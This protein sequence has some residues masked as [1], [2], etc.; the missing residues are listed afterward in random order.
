MT[1]LDHS[2]ESQILVQGIQS[3]YD[4]LVDMTD[5]YISDGF[6]VD[7]NKKKYVDNVRIILVDIKNKSLSDFIKNAMNKLYINLKLLS[8]RKIRHIQQIY[9]LFLLINLYN[10]YS[11][12]FQLNNKLKKNNFQIKIKKMKYSSVSKFDEIFYNDKTVYVKYLKDE[13]INMRFDDFGLSKILNMVY[14]NY[15]VFDFN[16]KYDNDVILN[17]CDK[18][19][20]NSFIECSDNGNFFIQGVDSKNFIN[21]KN[22][23]IFVKK[24]DDRSRQNYDYKS[25][26]I[27]NHLTFDTNVM[28]I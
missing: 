19:L 24:R 14:D 22:F 6:I 26:L 17:E 20:R 7:R 2:H 27:N 4:K 16:I 5:Q 3:Y 8:K 11:Y 25:I 12:I 13:I 23:T 1:D 10:M 21:A 15:S 18:L 28:F 9:E